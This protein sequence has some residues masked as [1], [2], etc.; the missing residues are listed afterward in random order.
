MEAN[1]CEQD[2]LR[3]LY[4]QLPIRTLQSR[5]LTPL[6]R[7][8]KTDLTPLSTTATAPPGLV[9]I[10]LASWKDTKV[11]IRWLGSEKGFKFPTDFQNIRLVSTGEPSCTWF[12]EVKVL[13]S[14]YQL[15]Y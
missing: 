11:H 3:V 8:V 12:V 10:R 15:A 9:I 5:H 6:V 4:G 2:E 13:S 7:S 14:V 1:I